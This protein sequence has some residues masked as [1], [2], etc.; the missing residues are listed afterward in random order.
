MTIEYSLDI[1]DKIGKKKGEQ[2]IANLQGEYCCLN[3]EK[4]GKVGSTVQGVI[5]DLLTRA[6]MHET[7]FNNDHMMTI[8]TQSSISAE[9]AQRL[10][11]Q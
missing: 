5:A 4:R 3:C 10:E 6:R 9:K 11:Q 1:A 8:K 7:R 2:E